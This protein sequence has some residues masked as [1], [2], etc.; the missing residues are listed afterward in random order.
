MLNKFNKIKCFR[1]EHNV[2]GAPL[3]DPELQETATKAGRLKVKVMVDINEMID[4]EGMGNFNEVIDDKVLDESATIMLTDLS[5]KPVGTKNGDI[6][7]SV[8]AQLEEF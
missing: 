4:A 2:L 1:Q 6:V 8:E 3:T 7:L 5:Y